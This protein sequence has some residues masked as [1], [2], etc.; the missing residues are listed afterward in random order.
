MPRQCIM[1]IQC[2]ILIQSPCVLSW[3]S[4]ACQAEVTINGG[5]KMSRYHTIRMQICCYQRVPW[6]SWICLCALHA[7]SAPRDEFSCERKSWHMTWWWWPSVTQPVANASAACTVPLAVATVYFGKHLLK[8]TNIYTS[9]KCIVRSSTHL[10]CR[11][12]PLRK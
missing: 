7:T 8:W 3:H 5:T 6:C 11:C 2:I 9:K 12:T 1:L 4:C 10:Y